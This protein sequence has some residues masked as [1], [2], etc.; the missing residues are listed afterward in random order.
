MIL[1]KLLSLLLRRLVL[2]ICRKVTDWILYYCRRAGYPEHEIRSARRALIVL[3]R[4]LL[5]LLM[6]RFMSIIPTTPSCSR[7][8][9]GCAA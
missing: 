8:T 5:H 1:K 6:R 3:M 4:I 2:H 9:P 7:N